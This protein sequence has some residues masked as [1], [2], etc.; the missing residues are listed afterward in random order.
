MGLKQTVSGWYEAANTSFGRHGIV[1]AVLLFV[2]PFVSLGAI[3]GYLATTAEWYW[4]HLGWLGV[5]FAVLGTWIL[6]GGALLVIRA[7]ANPAWLQLKPRLPDVVQTA[8]EINFGKTSHWLSVRSALANL[9]DKDS[10]QRMVAALS[11]SVE[12]GNKLS[13]IQENL[14]NLSSSAMYDGV[15]K[16]YT[17][18]ALNLQTKMPLLENAYN[19]AIAACLFDLKIKLANG[20]LISKGFKCPYHGEGAPEMLKADQWHALQFDKSDTDW[21]TAHADGV[22]YIGIQVASRT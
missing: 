10:Y 2:L 12:N 21:Q 7:L 18:E 22:K 14:S 15:R 3:A 5:W 1:W 11:V 20:L 16:N 6:L 17:A 13:A 4:H 8:T 19:V 9:T